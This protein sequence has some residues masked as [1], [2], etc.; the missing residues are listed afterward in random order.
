MMR[1]TRIERTSCR[2]VLRPRPDGSTEQPPELPVITLL[3]CLPKP[4]KMDLIVRQA[5]EAGVSRI[6]PLLSEHALDTGGRD[7]ARMARWRR[8]CREAL[9]QSGNPRLVVIEEPVSLPGVCADPGDWGTAIFFH[10]EPLEKRSLHE[11]LAQER[12]AVSILVGPE[13][14]LAPGEVSL[15][16]QRGFQPAWLGH[17]VL[18]VETA[19]IYAIG[20]VKTIL[21]EREAWTPSSEK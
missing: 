11:M 15:L 6:V 14:G 21:Q 2:V 9:Q 12:R 1:L 3:Q 5:A 10:E 17:A 8:I 13:G 19:A 16:R 20:A 18:R 4:G 7:A